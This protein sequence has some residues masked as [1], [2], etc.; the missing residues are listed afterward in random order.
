MEK[1]TTKIMKT[2]FPKRIG[3]RTKTN[4]NQSLANYGACIPVR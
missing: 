3:S 4:R 2:H 1:I